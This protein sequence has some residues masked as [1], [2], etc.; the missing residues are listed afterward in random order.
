M[1]KLEETQTY[2]IGVHLGTETHLR[3]EVHERRAV[4]IRVMFHARPLQFIY[5]AGQLLHC[6][7]PQLEQVVLMTI[8]PPHLQQYS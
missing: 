1:H 3:L 5:E 6:W 7:W 8:M 4:T 2:T